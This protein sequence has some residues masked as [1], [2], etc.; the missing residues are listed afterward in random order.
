MITLLS[1]CETAVVKS[2]KEN[3][4]R[5][6]PASGS[7]ENKSPGAESSLRS[8]LSALSEPFGLIRGSKYYNLHLG[9]KFSLP[10]GWT[11]TDSAA[12]KKSIS[13]SAGEKDRAYIEKNLYYEIA[14]LAG[15][16]LKSLVLMLE[17]M[18]DNDK[19]AFVSEKAY[20]KQLLADLTAS[21][22]GYKKLSSGSLSFAAH[23]FTAL[24]MKAP[25][26]GVFEAYFSLRYGNYMVNII[27]RDK[28][29]KAGSAL[30]KFFEEYK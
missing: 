14:A 4:A 7:P 2:T 17:D 22:A 20:Q 16:G 10:D 11:Y 26:D 15:D 21:D 18:R 9:I 6:E 24:Y 23:K 3:A 13:E 29:E 8:E 30:Q 28:V 1:A 5:F 19:S 25:G 12:F 27:C